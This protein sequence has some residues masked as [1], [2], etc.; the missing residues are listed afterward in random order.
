VFW[1]DGSS[2]KL[3]A[4]DPPFVATREG[5]GR[6]HIAFHPSQSYAY[7]VNELDSTVTTY[8]Y[9]AGGGVLQPV[10]VVPATP[11]SFTGNNTGAEIAVAPSGSFVY[12]SNRG[13]DSIA[14]FAVDHAQGTLTP[15]GWEPTQGKT[16]RFFT[17]EPAAN[18]LYAANQ[19]GDTIVTFRVNPATGRLTPTGQ[20]VQTGSPVCII[21]VGG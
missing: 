9:H 4:N 20:V 16:P 15:V 14:I 5:A 19:E 3:T 2:G 11:P 8:R 1:L 21:F 7:V 13:H 6:R 17:F 18:F 10:Q 12:A